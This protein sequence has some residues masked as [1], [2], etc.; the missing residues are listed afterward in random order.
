MGR[1]RRPNGHGRIVGQR[2][3]GRVVTAAACCRN[4][5]VVLSLIGCDHGS[6]VV[7]CSLDVFSYGTSLACAL[8]VAPTQNSIGQHI[9][10]SLNLIKKN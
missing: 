10:L 6:G 7:G 8:V 2:P 5:V 1:S 4:F 9:R 3:R